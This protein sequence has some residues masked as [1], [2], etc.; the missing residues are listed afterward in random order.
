MAKNEHVNFSEL[1]NRDLVK[2][3]RTGQVFIFKVYGNN[4]YLCTN[5]VIQPIEHCE[6]RNYIFLK[7]SLNAYC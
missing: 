6:E 1:N 2:D 4:K 7:K 5:H 3:I